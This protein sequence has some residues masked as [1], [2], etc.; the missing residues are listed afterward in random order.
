MLTFCQAEF[1]AS[2]LL[3]NCNLRHRQNSAQ[4]HSKTAFRSFETIYRVTSATSRRKPN[5]LRAGGATRG[6][7]SAIC[8]LRPG[9]S[10]LGS[11]G[12][13]GRR[14]AVAWARNACS[15]PRR[16]PT[17]LLGEHHRCAAAPG[18][19][20][21]VRSAP[22][23]EPSTPTV[24]LCCAIV[25]TSRRDVFGF[26]YHP[27]RLARPGELA[28]ALVSPRV[29][30]TLPRRSPLLAPAP[31][32][33][34]HTRCG[35]LAQAEAPPVPAGVLDARWGGP[36]RDAAPAAFHAGGQ[37]HPSCTYVCTPDPGARQR[38]SRRLV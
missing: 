1:C 18:L 14:C 3:A 10:T 27:A 9:S 7:Q 38:H 22:V 21:G 13:C 37:E 24:R 15:D 31:P 34:S 33:R 4:A 12:H 2:G 8:N 5:N 32:L 29:G 26:E 36:R 35:S 30:T 17:N 20:F 11:R 28:P 16:S 23:H 19:H 6:L 25:A